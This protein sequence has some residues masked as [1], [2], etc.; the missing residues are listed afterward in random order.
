MGRN[1]SELAFRPNVLTVYT[2][3]GTQE[4]R[5]VWPPSTSGALLS[6]LE[7][8]AEVKADERLCPGELE[9]GHMSG[10]QE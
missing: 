2:V 6:S 3:W 9:V 8:K 7:V 5:K 10:Q 1:H 4:M